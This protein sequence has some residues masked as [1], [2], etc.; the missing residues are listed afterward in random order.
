MVPQAAELSR[1]P[2]PAGQALLLVRIKT[3]VGFDRH[4]SFW[5]AA[6]AL[7][8]L[9]RCAVRIAESRLKLFA[10]WRRP[11]TCRDVGHPL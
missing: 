1:L 10:L 11:K 2:L 8:H 9:W 6:Y 5:L 4:I 7:F 3:P